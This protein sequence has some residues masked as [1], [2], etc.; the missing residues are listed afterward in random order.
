[1]KKKKEKIVVTD[2]S[3]LKV[4][5]TLAYGSSTSRHYAPSTHKT[6]L[7]LRLSLIRVSN[8]EHGIKKPGLS[9]IKQQF[10]HAQGHTWQY[11]TR[12]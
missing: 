10:K 4:E 5:K 2:H 3:F 1:M 7:F 9:F 8:T 12:K 11:P 6:T